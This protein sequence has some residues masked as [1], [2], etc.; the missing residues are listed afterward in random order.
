MRIF[1]FAAGHD[2]PLD[3]EVVTP[4]TA[5]G[6]KQ[7][8]WEILDLCLRDRRQAWVLTSDG[9]YA[10]LR[11]ERAGE[12]PETVGIHA[13]LMELTRHRARPLTG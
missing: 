11:S 9:R 10:Q 1:H 3:V 6:P 13:T 12:E 8:L 5:P 2:A 4:V 7:R